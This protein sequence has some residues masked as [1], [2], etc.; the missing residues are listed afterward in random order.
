[1]NARSVEFE[2]EN[3]PV[4]RFTGSEPPASDGEY[5]YEP[6][7]GPGHLHLQERL[8][9]SDASCSYS[10]AGRIVRFRVVACPS[11]GMLLLSSF[12]TRVTGAK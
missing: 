2:Y 12:D 4:G 9:E 10:D 7:R 11:Y 6:Y 3:E 8:K 1:M 5:P